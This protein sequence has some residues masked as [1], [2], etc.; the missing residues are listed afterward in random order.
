LGGAV[1]PPFNASQDCQGK[2]LHP[3][4]SCHM[5]FDYA[6]TTTGTFSSTSSG[7]WNGQPFNITLTGEGIAP[8]DTT[9]PVLSLPSTIVVDAT[10]PAGIAV[11]FAVS[12]TDD[13]DPRPTVVCT[14]SS[15]SVFPIGTTTVNCTASDASGNTA[16]GS[17]A[18]QVKGAPAQLADLAVAV[19]GVGP[20]KSLERK[21]S[22]AQRLVASGEIR[23]A[24]PALTGF[25]S[26]VQAQSGKSI[27]D[28]RATDLIADAGRIKSVLACG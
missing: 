5:F 21:V 9:P 17:F 1:F 15:G 28:A 2:T 6:P 4:D 25:E 13:I 3:G 23:T 14:P 7:S 22:V 10:G 8:V 11:T 12:A 27:P 24:C 20:G 16:T 26:E 19:K 18:V